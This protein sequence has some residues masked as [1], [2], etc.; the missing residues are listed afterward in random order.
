MS[1]TWYLYL[2]F[3]AALLIREGRVMGWVLGFGVLQGLFAALYFTGRP[4]F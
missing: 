1:D 3:A 4:L 2:F